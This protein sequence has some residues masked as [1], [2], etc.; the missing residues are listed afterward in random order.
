MVGNEVTETAETHE[1]VVGLGLVHL[2]GLIE[3]EHLGML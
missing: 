3:V 2:D 1:E